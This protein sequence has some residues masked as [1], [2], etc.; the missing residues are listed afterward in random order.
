DAGVHGADGNFVQTFALD[1]QEF[2]SARLRRTWRRRERTARAPQTVIE[3]RPGFRRSLGL[4]AEQVAHGRL[5]AECRRMDT[6][7]RGKRASGAV[8]APPAALAPLFMHA[9]PSPL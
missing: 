5:E 4:H 3:P 8:E 2:V 6:G 1:R 7:D 9:P